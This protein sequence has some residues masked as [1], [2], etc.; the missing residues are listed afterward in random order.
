MNKN[1]IL[2][3]GA[4]GFVGQHVLR[5]LSELG[6]QITVVT[7]NKESRKF[8]KSF[9]IDR[10]VETK[11][12][13]LEDV[14]WWKIALMDVD[15]IVHLA[16]Y[17]EPNKYLHS[18]LNF[19]CL[20]GTLSIARA[21]TE[22][23][24][25]RFV[26]IGTC[27]EYDLSYGYLSTSTPLKPSSI[28]SATKISTF[29]ILSEW[30]KNHQLSFLWCRLF[31]LFGEGEDN[32]RLVSYIRERLEKG[33]PAELTSGRQIRD[34]LDVEEA[35]RLIVESV[36]S[37]KVGPLNICSGIPV[38]VRELAERIADEYNRRDLLRFG[39]KSENDVDPII[40]V[41]QKQ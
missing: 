28:Y 39:L 37:E 30:F 8:D 27:F 17:V 35:S 4:S 3:T 11:N 32:R 21:A 2:L 1:R 26:G 31:Y 29:M 38:S 34:Y 12:L 15:T 13:F 24:I 33:E 10:F 14:E 41:G 20:K 23:Q 19:D 22:L 6:H 25:S 40:I 18:R 9:N 36:F 16:W 5:R 7:R